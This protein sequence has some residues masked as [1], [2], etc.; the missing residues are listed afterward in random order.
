MEFKIYQCLADLSTKLYAA[1]HDLSESYSLCWQ[2]SSHIT[3]A[4]ASDIQSVTNEACFVTG[5]S[6]FLEDPTYRQGASGCILEVKFNQEDEFTLTVEC[7]IDFGKVLLRVKQ[8]YS[9]R[10]F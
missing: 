6:Y 2:D 5:V 4:I 3:E 7:L 1:S 10:N 8:K 9:N